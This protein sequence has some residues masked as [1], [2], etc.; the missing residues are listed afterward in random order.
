MGFLDEQLAVVS[1]KNHKQAKE[2]PNALSNKTYSIED[3][4]Q[5]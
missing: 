1:V 3:V 4:Y 2:N 5:F